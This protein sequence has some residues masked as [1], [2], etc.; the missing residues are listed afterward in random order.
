MHVTVQKAKTHFGF[1]ADHPRNP[2]SP[3][4]EPTSL[5]LITPKAVY[6]TAGYGVFNPKCAIRVLVAVVR[7]IRYLWARQIPGLATGAKVIE[8]KIH[9]IRKAEDKVRKS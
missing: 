3:Y 2:K 5:D 9:Q 7:M 1:W 6:Q 8:R 4:L